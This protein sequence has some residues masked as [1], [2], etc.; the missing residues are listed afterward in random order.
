MKKKIMS[1][2]LATAMVVSMTACV[3]KPGAA[4]S[5]GTASSGESAAAGNTTSGYELALITDVGTI[6]DKSLIRAHGRDWKNTQR[7]TTSPINIISPQKNQ[8]K[9]A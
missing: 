5:G 1:L 3:Q 6:D 7:T 8:M 4:S 2:F 9:P